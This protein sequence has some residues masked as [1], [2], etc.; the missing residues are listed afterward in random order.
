VGG[1]PTDAEDAAWEQQIAEDAALA[2]LEEEAMRRD[3]DDDQE[4][5]P[6]DDQVGEGVGWAVR[7]VGRS[8]G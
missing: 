3:D 2:Q 5:A 1:G 8:S 6:E 4:V 7:V